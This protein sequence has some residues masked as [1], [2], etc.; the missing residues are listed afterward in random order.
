[1]TT[2]I[3]KTPH[4]KGAVVSL[5]ENRQPPFTVKILK[6]VKKVSYE[7]HKLENLWHREASEQLED[8]TPEQKRGYCKLH[9]GIAIRKAEDDY[10]SEKYDEVIRPLTYMQ[11]LQLMLPPFDFP[12]TRDMSTRGKSQYLD[13]IYT[14]Y[15]S[16]GVTLTRPDNG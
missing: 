12:V 13:E 9:F 6:E 7:Q 11:K 1:V 15:T 14:H 2:R 4:D 5:I 3:I 8:E 10:F 16:L